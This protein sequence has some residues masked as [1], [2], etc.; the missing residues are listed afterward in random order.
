MNVSGIDPPITPAPGLTIAETLGLHDFYQTGLWNYCEGFYNINLD[1][2][3]VPTDCGPQSNGYYFDP[4]GIMSTEL[5]P[6]YTIVFVQAEVDAITTVH[7]NSSWLRAAFVITAIFTGFTLLI[8]P[9]T[10]VWHQRRLMNCLPVGCMCIGAFFF[11][12]GA[13][14]ATSVYFK[15]RDAFNNDTR[16]NVEDRKSV[17]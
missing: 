3:P 7:Q 6:P 13:V 17:V 10:G 11:F 4:I 9:L 1:W 5:L 8:G 16:L 15:L 12:C 14:T 2:A